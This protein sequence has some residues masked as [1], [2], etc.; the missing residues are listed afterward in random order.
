MARGR[1]FIT[2]GPIIQLSVGGK[3]PGETIEL[4]R[5][6]GKVTIRAELSSPRL[7][8][9]FHLVHNGKDLGANITR[10]RDD[11]IHRWFVEHHLVFKESGWIAAWGRGEPIKTQNFDA[12][13]HTNAVRVHV[14]DRPVRSKDDLAHFITLVTRQREYYLK[15]GRYRS[16]AERLHAVSVFD[17]ALDQLRRRL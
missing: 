1:V 6:G 9:E 10:T 3:R 7:L 11:P 13:A 5:E 2:G 14:G 12:M 4:P 17:R 16:E 15:Q 8:R